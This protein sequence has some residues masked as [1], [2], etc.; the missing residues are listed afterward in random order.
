[1]TIEIGIRS[2]VRGIVM[3]GT[4]T[5]E[6]GGESEGEDGEREEKERVLREEE[7]KI[8]NDRRLKK[9][10]EKKRLEAEDREAMRKDLRM[11]IRMH[12]GNVCEELHQCLASAIP[13]KKKDK[14]KLPVHASSEEESDEPKGSDV[15]AV[16][17]QTEELVIKEKRRRSVERP[18]GDSSPME[19]PAKRAST[20]DVLDPK[21]LLLSCRRQPFKRSPRKQTP[22]SLRSARKGKKVSTSPDTMGRLMFVTDNLRELGDRNMKDLKQICSSEDVPYE[23][24]RK[25]DMIIAITEKRSQVAYGPEGEVEGPT[26]AITKEGNQSEEKEESAG[27]DDDKEV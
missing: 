11:K 26:G 5:T 27:N 25:M 13:T 18:V 2:L 21:R 14:G 6:E 19:T 12:M 22:K 1:M 24:L 7:E 9:K 4:G 20:R 3:V 15:E 17:E 23:G 10:E 16:C 8:A